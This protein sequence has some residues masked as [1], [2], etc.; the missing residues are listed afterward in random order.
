MIVRINKTTDGY[1]TM[2]NYH[3]RDRNLTL[4]AKGLLSLVL[5]LPPDWKFSIAGLA[6]ISKEKETSIKTALEELKDNGYLVITKKMP[7]E[8]KT[9]RIEYEWDF[10]ERPVF[11][12]QEVKKQEVENL[13][14]ESLT[15]ENQGQINTNIPNTDLVNTKEISITPYIPR[16]IPSPEDDMFEHFWAAYPQCFRKANKKGCKAKFVK[17]KNLQALFPQIMYSLDVQ[18]RSKQWN[19]KDGEYIPAPLTWINQERWTITDARTEKQALADEA[20]TDFI[21][22]M[23]GGTQC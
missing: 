23:F 9:G 12:K 17:I 16:D 5:S 15:V 1:T 14:L 6:S 7:N 10:Y 20:A 8:T 4:K 18:K 3:L 22:N 21:N 11:T 2:S 13:T 19:E